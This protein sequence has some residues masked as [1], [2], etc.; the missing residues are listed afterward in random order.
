MIFQ[1]RYIPYQSTGAFTKIVEDYVAGHD[2]LRPF[3][4]HPPKPSAINDALEERKTYS[5]NRE[6][7]VDELRNQY[8][9]ITTH[10]RV[11]NNIECLLQETCFT[12]CTAHQP[13]IFTGHLYF[14]YKIIHAIRLAD[15]L[16]ATQPGYH[17]VPVYYMGSEDAD[18]EELGEVTINNKKYEWKTAQSG[19]VGRMKVDQPFINLV[20]G[21]ESQLA[22]E[23]F[24][25]E[26]MS[27]VRR[28]YSIGKTI[29]QA[30]FELVNELFREKGLVVLLPD[31][32]GLKAVFAAF[33]K[34]ELTEQ[35]SNAAV[36]QAVESF[37]PEYKVQAAG[38]SINLFYLEEDKRERIDE[39]KGGFALADNS[40][41]FTQEEILSEVDRNPGH[42]SPN[43]IL[44]PLFQEMILPNIAFIGGG[45]EL[46]YWLE[47]KQM[48]VESGVPFPILVLRNSF[49]LLRNKTA[50]LIGKLK[51]GEEAIFQPADKILSTV[52]AHESELRLTLG[53][54]KE[55]LA[56]IYEDIRKPAMAVDETLNRHVD[57][58]KLKALQK[59]EDLEKKMLRAEKKKFEAINRQVLKLKQALFPSGSLQ[60]RVEN[61]LPYVASYGSNFLDEIYQNS[62]TLE[63]EFCI[64]EEKVPNI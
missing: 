46:A 29:E 13:N 5:Y 38:R 61:M 44:R 18:L 51:I 50:A 52:V 40:K 19:A 30:T 20:D 9:G 63:Q 8:A 62:L 17:F 34:K 59:I 27:M 56:Q 37:P 12:V 64:L 24:G 39:V 32:A 55:R 49:M 57:V 16:N 41:K 54:E 6:V 21:I 2:R 23:P 33:V 43:V 58:I 45:G 4:T 25:N 35:F 28:A 1:A 47:L 48:F 31:N 26:V 7:L 53:S 22:V 11:R 14:I 15:E 60:E 36:S 3:Y 42:F 10:D